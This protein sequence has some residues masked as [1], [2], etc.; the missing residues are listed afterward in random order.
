MLQ[1]KRDLLKQNKN[2]AYSEL[3]EIILK[4]FL[5]E[6]HLPGGRAKGLIDGVQGVI[7]GKRLSLPKLNPFGAIIQ[8]WV[9]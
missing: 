3:I 9:I 6:Y 7:K 5:Q 4:F 1:Q 2:P 8:A